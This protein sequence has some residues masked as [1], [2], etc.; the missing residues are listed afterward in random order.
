MVEAFLQAARLR[1]HA[2]AP[3][4]AAPLE[5]LLALWAGKLTGTEAADVAWA[6]GKLQLKLRASVAKALAARLVEGA[7][8]LNPTKATLALQAAAQ[9]VL[10]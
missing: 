8:S 10:S 1:N 2:A 7:Q 4:L 9:G 6:C 5:K 3:G